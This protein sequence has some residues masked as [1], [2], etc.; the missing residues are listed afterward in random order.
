MPAVGQ[1]AIGIESRADDTLTR[2]RLAPLNHAPTETA[3][4]AE[5]AFLRVLD[6]S[7]KTPIAGHARFVDGALVFD[8]LI[9]RPDGSESHGT[10]RRGGPGEA[11]ALGLDAGAS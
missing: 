9:L 1:G 5:R 2:E 10:A 7:C 4:I 3:L 8:G 6:G 11:E